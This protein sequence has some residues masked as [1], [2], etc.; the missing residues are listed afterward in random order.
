[1]LILY[2]PPSSARRKPVMP[3]SL[4]ALGALLDGRHDYT[5]V[6]GNL[7][8]RPLETIDRLVREH[9][10]SILGVTVM[11]GP[12]LSDAVPLCSS[13][14]AKHPNL[15]IIWGGYFPTQHFDACLRS[16]YV[17]YVV[18]G[19]GEVV[20]QSLIDALVAGEDPTGLHG[21]AYMAANGIPTSN[22]MAP[23]PHPDSL[24]DFPY[25]RVDVQRYA[26]K[27]FMGRRT[28]PHHSS[29]GCPFF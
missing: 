3:L 14:K 20:F 13:L 6:D 25:E 18:R 16:G 23:I 26:R 21:L 7:D 17:D 9:S 22:A 2:N 15:A 10:A 27:T 19:H 12:Q 28:L 8:P 11:P 1:M 4:L 24:P 29:Y 5:I